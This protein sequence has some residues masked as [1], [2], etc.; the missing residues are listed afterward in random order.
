MPALTDALDIETSQ[1]ELEAAL[2][3]MLPRQEVS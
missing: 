2:L 1:K 3:D